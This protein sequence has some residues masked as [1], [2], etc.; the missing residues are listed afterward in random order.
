M[1]RRTAASRP[2][3]EERWK[4]TPL[5][6]AVDQAHTGTHDVYSVALPPAATLDGTT[7]A[8][9]RYRIF[10]PRRMRARVCTPDGRIAPG[11]TIIQR[12]LLG[13]VALEMA[14]RVIETGAALFTYATLEGHSERG[15]ATFAVREAKG[16][17]LAF[18]IESWS[19]PGNLLAK[20]GRPV[21]RAAQQ[22]FTREALLHFR[23]HL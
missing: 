22:K 20:L 17:G 21:A 4:A 10:P 6:L 23:D 5:N 15:I 19:T 11:V 13:P 8:L 18:E 9:L 2:F 3:D 16:G 14:V 12:V 7:D 1:A